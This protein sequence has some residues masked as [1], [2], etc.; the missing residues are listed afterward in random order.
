LGVVVEDKERFDI[1]GV[2][3]GEPIN[4]GW[5]LGVPEGEFK[6]CGNTF[7]ELEGEQEVN[8]LV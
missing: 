1:V 2:L 8:V 4:V 3:D 5:N 6:V 7:G